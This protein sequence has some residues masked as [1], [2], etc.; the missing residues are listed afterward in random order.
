[1]LREAP[2]YYQMWGAK[3]TGSQAACEALGG[4]LAFSATG[5]REPAWQHRRI[6]EYLLGSSAPAP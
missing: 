3:S 6:R 1:V 4:I 2:R 5:G